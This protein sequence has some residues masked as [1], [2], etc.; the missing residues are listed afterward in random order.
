[1]TQEQ[2]QDA[3]PLNQCHSCKAA[4]IW[5]ATATAAMPLDAEPSSAG[6]VELTL[7]RGRWRARVLTTAERELL[8]SEPLVLR[9]AHFVTCPH[10]ELWRRKPARPAP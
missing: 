10:A 5:A 9:T 4:I 2:T 7:D 8:A 6:N 3:P 1:M